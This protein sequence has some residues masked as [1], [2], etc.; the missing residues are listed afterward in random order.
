MLVRNTKDFLSAFRQSGRS[1]SKPDGTAGIAF[2]KTGANA[3][4]GIVN[5]TYQ[6]F[7]HGLVGI[8]FVYIKLKLIIQIIDGNI[9]GIGVRFKANR[10]IGQVC[11][12]IFLRSSQTVDGKRECGR[13]S[14]TSDIAGKLGG[15]NILIRGVSRLLL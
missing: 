11:P 3:E 13:R 4:I 2:V 14:S 15:Y 6:P 10:L 8:V 7:L 5:Q 1:R 12:H 9:K